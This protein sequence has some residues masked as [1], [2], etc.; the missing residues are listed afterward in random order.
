MDTVTLQVGD[1]LKHPAFYGIGGTFPGEPEFVDGKFI[2]PDV[3]P[4]ITVTIEDSTITIDA[5]DLKNHEDSEDYDGRVCGG[6]VFL[7]STDSDSGIEY[8]SPYTMKYFPAKMA[9]FLIEHDFVFN[10]KKYRLVI[11]MYED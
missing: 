7:Y 2:K 6:E 11:P 9:E 3:T 4:Y 5:H 1:L 8:E 10:G